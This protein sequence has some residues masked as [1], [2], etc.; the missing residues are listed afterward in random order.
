MM[1]V[2]G[3]SLGMV[4][5]EKLEQGA[6]RHKMFSHGRQERVPNQQNLKIVLSHNHDDSDAR[7]QIRLC[8]RENNL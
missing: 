7:E 6:R 3:R 5:S 1:P 8:I 4:P 2:A